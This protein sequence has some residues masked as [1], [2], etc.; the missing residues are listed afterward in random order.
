[1]RHIIAEIIR[2][3]GGVVGVAV[4]G[5]WAYFIWGLNWGDFGRRSWNL[6]AFSL[7]GGTMLVFLGVAWFF[8]RIAEDISPH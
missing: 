2:W 1:M 8:W 7:T 4:A 3:T 5:F 6:G